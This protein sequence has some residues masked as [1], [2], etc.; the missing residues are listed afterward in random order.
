MTNYILDG[1]DLSGLFDSSIN[2]ISFAKNPKKISN[3]V[4]FP[5]ELDQPANPNFQDI[6]L[7]FENN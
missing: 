5:H 4:K 1:Y 6:E 7:V 2:P 3:L